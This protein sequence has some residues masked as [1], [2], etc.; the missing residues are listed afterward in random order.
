ME[1]DPVVGAV[2][3]LGDKLGVAMP[4]TRT[5]YASTKLLEATLMNR[6]ESS[7]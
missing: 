6:K 7:K 1:L 3:E 2:V 5:V 4:H